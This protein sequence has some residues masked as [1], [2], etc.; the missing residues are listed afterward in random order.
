MNE[1]LAISPSAKDW[2]SYW[3]AQRRSQT[4]YSFVA[5]VYRKV[6]ISRSLSR[7]FKRHVPQRSLCLHAG[8]GSGEVDTSLHNRWRVIGLDFSHQAVAKYHFIHD[9]KVSVLQADNF[10]LPFSDNTF[11]CVFN[12]GVM[13]HFSINEIRQMA[14][15]FN[16][17]LVPGGKVILFWP[18]TYGLSVVVLKLI[19]YV[20]RLIQPDF[21]PLH[22]RE[23]SLISSRKEVQ[24]L[25]EQACFQLVEFRFEFRDAFTHEVV[26]AKKPGPKVG[27]PMATTIAPSANLG[28]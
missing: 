22:P 1:D 4:I 28:T 10:H 6:V 3:L 15:E 7:N 19:H 12:L 23:I 25:L 20:A 16:R 21:K 8:A 13:E 17:V 27:A 24:L 9:Q 14:S 11:D 18:P 26:V 5:R 2:D